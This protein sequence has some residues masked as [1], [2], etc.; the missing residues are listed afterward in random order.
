MAFV[1]GGKGPS[2]LYAVS[3]TFFYYFLNQYDDII[4]YILVCTIDMEKALKDFFFFFP[5]LI[6]ETFRSRVN[7]FQRVSHNDDNG[8]IL[9]MWDDV[10]INYK[11]S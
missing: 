10:S 8:T 3:L 6:L 2:S 5:F 4:Q 11:K 7:N 1:D 9:S